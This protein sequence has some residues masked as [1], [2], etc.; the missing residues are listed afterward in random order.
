MGGG[1]QSRV[2]VSIDLVQRTTVWAGKKGEVVDT[3]VRL[4]YVLGNNVSLLPPLLDLKRK[5]KKEDKSF[6]L[7]E[8]G[9]GIR[10]DGRDDLVLDPFNFSL[11]PLEVS[12]SLTLQVDQL[13]RDI[14][15]LDGQTR[16]KLTLSFVCLFVLLVS[17]S[18]PF[19]PSSTVVS[20]IHCTKSK[21][22]GY[23]VKS[24]YL[25]D[26]LHRSILLLSRKNKQV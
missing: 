6:R 3:V 5:Q 19:F 22:R 17:P 14:L 4:L 9:R 16:S 21:L 1:Q 18:F 15:N 25:I 20:C 26:F 2:S 8:G 13:L 7:E 24:F 23:L 12:F 10:Q 11:R